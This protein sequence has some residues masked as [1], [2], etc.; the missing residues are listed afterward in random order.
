MTEIAL[1]TNEDDLLLQKINTSIYDRKI[2]SKMINLLLLFSFP[3]QEQELVGSLFEF[4]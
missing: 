2:E 4:V 1:I 3:S